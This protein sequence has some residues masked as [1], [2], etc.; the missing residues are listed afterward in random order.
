MFW[1]P[2]FVPLMLDA[3]RLPDAVKFPTPV[4]SPVVGAMNTVLAFNAFALLP[5]ITLFNVSVPLDVTFPNGIP[6]TVE[7]EK[8]IVPLT[9]LLPVM[10]ALFTFVVGCANNCAAAMIVHRAAKI[11]MECGMR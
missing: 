3:E 6:V 9:V 7:L 4:M 8:S 11:F 2:V 10:R 1:S 5:T